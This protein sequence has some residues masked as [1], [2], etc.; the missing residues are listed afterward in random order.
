MEAVA[1]EIMALVEG[2]K[3]TNVVPMPRKLLSHFP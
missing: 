1:A 2:K 3:A